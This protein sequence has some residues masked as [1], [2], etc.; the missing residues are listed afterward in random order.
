MVVKEERDEDEWRR[1]CGLVNCEWWEEKVYYTRRCWR[2]GKEG[3]SR[4]LSDD[5]APK[6]LSLYNGIRWIPRCRRQKIPLSILLFFS[7]AYIHTLP[8][9]LSIFTCI[10]RLKREQPPWNSMHRYLPTCLH[11]SLFTDHFIYYIFYSKFSNS[12]YII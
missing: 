11:H 6:A 2:W 10:K 9:S 4:R 12:L 5:E 1:R 8:L 3:K 7:L